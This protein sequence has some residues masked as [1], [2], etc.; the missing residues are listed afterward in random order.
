[1]KS[2]TAFT[3]S[4]VNRALQRSAL[5]GGFYGDPRSLALVEKAVEIGVVIRLST[6]Q[7]QW[8]DDDSPKA[9]AEWISNFID[10]SNGNAPIV[11]YENA[12]TEVTYYELY[13]RDGSGSVPSIKVN[14]PKEIAIIRATKEFFEKGDT[15]KRV[16]I[17]TKIE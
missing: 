12:P 11:T 3:V 5:V 1:M 9:C 6:T 2:R 13:P 10:Y 14:T 15:Y 7:A 4:A 8:K 16:V 17:S